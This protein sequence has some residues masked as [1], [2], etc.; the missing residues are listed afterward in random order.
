MSWATSLCAL[1]DA[2]AN[3]AGE[4][5]SWNGNELTL[6]PLG[7]DTMKAQIEI[8]IDKYGN[9]M[10]ARTVEKCESV[11]IVPY[12]ERRTNGLK[13]LP[14]FDK[15]QFIAGDFLDEITI[16]FKEKSESKKRQK[17]IDGYNLYYKE[18]EEWCLSEY[19]H[20][21]VK[22]IFDYISKKSTIKDL[23]AEKV[24]IKDSNGVLYD[25]QK[26][27]DVN[28]SNAFVRFRVYSI[29]DDKYGSAVWL[30]K[31]VQNSFINYYLS[32]IKKPENKTDICFIAGTE[33]S[34]ANTYPV[35][36]RGEWDT[37]A[38]LISSNDDKNFTY[39]GRFETKDKKN[40]FNEALSI[41]YQTS[42]KIHNALKWVIRRQGYV[43]DGLCIVA[44]ESNLNDMPNFY[45]NAA[46]MIK[47]FE[48]EKKVEHTSDDILFKEEKVKK[49]YT[50]Y[51]SAK[52]LNM[53][54]DGYYK[55]LN[56]TSL[57]VVISLNSA[58]PGRLAMTYY[59][60][61][62]TSR[63]L[64]NI[65]AWQESCCWRHEY[66]KD[67][68]TYQYEGMASINET[69]NSIYGSELNKKLT[70]QKSGD[71]SPMLISIFDRLLPCIIDNAAI[72]RDIVRNAVEKASNPIVYEDEHNYIRVLHIACS[73]VKRYYWKKGE[74]F[75]MKLDEKSTDRSYLFG[76]L[77][78]VAE[79]VERSTFK[80]G[81]TRITN[82]ERYMQQFSRTPFRTWE[83]IRINT[84]IYLK[85][86]NPSS[87]EYYKNLFAKITEL[88]NDG[89]FEEKKALDGKFLLGY[90]CQ[91][92]AL[93]YNKNDDIDCADD[94]LNNTEMEEN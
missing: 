84:Q 15:L 2:N 76:R 74:K 93:K 43:H 16:D 68:N 41:G 6:L 62:E 85:Q 72:P 94:E 53:A 25:T 45:D 61:L 47:N 27:Q 91:R 51:K 92:T 33:H 5:K 44:W 13:P 71:K 59:K 7:Y 89:S 32:T 77:L 8:T 12:P 23:I 18:L 86:L 82:A 28:I 52:D 22:A 26:I 63:Y 42:R 30:D 88:F 70:L 31:E 78:A 81:E 36:I 83:L 34:F 21:K 67:N 65:R 56:D 46:T 79:K 37:K 66:F 11:T 49:N 29:D 54:I 4:P 38:S 75:Y 80:Y 60:E 39:R 90:D 24:L 48:S 50:N 87:R 58:T 57:M 40:N 19:S 55:K 73:L 17:Y 3:Q 1:Y 69:V 14:L 9:F 64:E 35:K 20:P 10:L